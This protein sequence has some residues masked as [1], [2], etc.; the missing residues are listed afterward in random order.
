[1]TSVGAMLVAAACD[2]PDR[3]FLRWCR[4]EDRVVWS[5]AEAAARV[6]A[7]AARLDALGIDAGEHVVIHTDAMVPS[8][9]F[10]LACAVTGVV[11]TPVETSSQ[12]VVLSLCART[13][14]RAILTTPDRGTHAAGAPPILV[15]DGQAPVPQSGDAIARLRER[16]ARIETRATYMLQPTS[17]T[18]GESKLV[19]RDHSAFLRIATLLGMGLDRTAEPPARVLMVAALTHGMGQYLL[20]VALQ[21]AGELVVTS[22]IDV[23]ASLAEV[24]ALDPTIIG[25]T[26]RVLKSFATQAGAEDRIFG[27]SAA[28]FISGGAAPDNELL[29][30]IARHGLQIVEG[31][32]ASEISLVAMTRLGEWRPGVVG[33]VLDDVTLRITADGELEAFTPVML[34]GYHGAPELTRAAITDDGFYRTGDRIEI[35][36]DG[37]CRYLGRVVDTFNLFDG[38]HVVPGPIEDAIARLPWVEQVV[39][40]GD[41]RPYLS[42]VLVPVAED[43]SDV[44]SLRTIAERDLG[45][46]CSPLPPNARVRR[47][48]ILDRPLPAAIHQVV[49]HG[50]VRRARE[51]AITHLA[52]LVRALYNGGQPP[53]P[54]IAIVD[55][56]GAAHE[57]RMSSRHLRVWQVEIHAGDQAFAAFTRDV[58]RGGAYLVHPEQIRDGVVLVIEIELDDQMLALEAELVR[59]DPAGSVVRWTGPAG[60]LDELARHLPP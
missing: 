59:Q 20:A 35:S 31:Y 29:K 27:P 36:P 39:L 5:Y 43:R 53:G 45:Q 55:V 60:A 51:A 50:K 46:I 15:E 32:G 24:R 42:G 4:G 49:G 1:M 16:V 28:Y 21:L 30:R 37:A 25:L 10:D 33:H 41:Q 9:L 48:A 13:D 26:P 6:E 23:G 19:I 52:D 38:S 40:F 12:S 22:A 2:Y 17:G 11:F 54:G 3:T 7:L 8:I 58:G 18:T 44:A 14:A 47:V 56:P 57:R 34:R